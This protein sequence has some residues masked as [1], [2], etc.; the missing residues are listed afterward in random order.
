MLEAVA[1]EALQVVTNLSVEFM[2][3]HRIQC[4][5]SEVLEIKWQDPNFSALQELDVRWWHDMAPVAF[6]LSHSPQLHHVKFNNE[7]PAP[8]DFGATMLHLL[9]EHL[10]PRLR[11][12]ELHEVNELPGAG[13]RLLAQHCPNLEKLILTASTNDFTE[14]SIIMLLKSCSKLRALYLHGMECTPAVVQAAQTHCPEAQLLN[15][16]FEC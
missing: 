8:N 14:E 1:A 13:L 2:V 3:L 15:M 9:A 16:R 6:L 11:S 10:G 4:T 12:V 7:N 5:I